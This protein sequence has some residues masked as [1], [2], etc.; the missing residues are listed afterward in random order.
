MPFTWQISR[1]RAFLLSAYGMFCRTRGWCADHL[2]VAIHHWPGTTDPTAAS[3][4]QHTGESSVPSGVVQGPGQAVGGRAA[5]EI[6]QYVGPAP[7]GCSIVGNFL[8]GVISSHQR[9]SPR[10]RVAAVRR[11]FWQ[12][13]GADGYAVLVHDGLARHRQQRLPD[14][15]PIVLIK[16]TEGKGAVLE[17]RDNPR[18]A[19]AGQTLETPWDHLHGLYF[20][21]YA[22][23][24]YLNLPFVATRPDVDVQEI[25][26]WHEGPGQDWRRLRLT[27]PPRIATHNPVQDLYVDSDGLI[28]RHDYSPEVVGSNLA[29][30]YLHGYAEYDGIMFPRPRKVLPRNSDNRV[31]TAIGHESLLIG[32]QFDGNYTLT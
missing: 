31:D 29:A 8:L 12:A 20:G 18:A 24:T 3:G 1:G 11:A 28:V 25:E 17:A 23:W 14:G 10:I 2:S 19:F 27:F 9:V 5:Q 21:G 30:H 32:I 16:P 22:L 4:Q 6:G 13:L 26:P 15:S 7:A